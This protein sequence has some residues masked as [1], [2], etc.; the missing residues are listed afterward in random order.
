MPYINTTAAR[1]CR[2][3]ENS[4]STTYTTAAE[5]VAAS[6][7]SGEITRCELTAENLETLQVECDD[8]VEGDEA[9]FWGEDD[10]GNEWRVH[11]ARK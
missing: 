8:S 6:A 5:A 3:Q 11:V 2:Q 4:M 10:A 1:C 9:E 7:Q